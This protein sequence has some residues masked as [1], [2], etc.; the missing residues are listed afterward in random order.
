[1]LVP[2]QSQD[3]VDDFLRSVFSFLKRKTSYM[4]RE[5]SD[6]AVAKIAREYQAKPKV[7]VRTPRATSVSSVH[8]ALTYIICRSLRRLRMYV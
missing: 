8:L 5:G 6:K 2:M 3:N 1:M 7:R 4:Q